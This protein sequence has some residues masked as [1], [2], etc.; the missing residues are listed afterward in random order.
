M[1]VFMQLEAHKRRNLLILFAGGLLFW[2]SLASLL[3]T[4]PQYIE[5]VGASRQQIGIVMGCFAIGLLLSRTKLGHLADQHSR[6]LALIVGT[7]VV[8]LAPLGYLQVD[9]IGWL[10]LLR[11]FHGIS[12]AAFT[13]GYSALVA[14]LSPRYQRGELIG[15]M[16]LVTPTG[17]AL[18]PALGSFLQTEVGYSAL[19]L[20]AGGLGFLSLICCSFVYEPKRMQTDKES[21]QPNSHNIWQLLLSPRLRIPALVLLLAGFAFGAIG[22]FVALF[23]RETGIALNP[24]LYFTTAAIVNFCLRL[25]TGRASDRYGRGLFIS[26]SLICYG[27]AMFLLSTAQTPQGFLLAAM[28]QGAGA[29]TLLPVMIALIADR[30]AANERGRVFSAC[31]SGFDLGIALAGPIFGALADLLGY[32]GIF[33]ITTAFILVALIIFVTQSSQD[34]SHS[35]RFAIGREQ[36]I[37]ALEK[38]MQ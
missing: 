11:A 14:D 29:G 35:L 32:Q 34:L 27:L 31:I 19:F 13:T 33:S 9:S 38:R 37:Y 24:G 12:L 6:K 2:S 20:V 23:I 16:S 22:T 5:D 17:L 8:A 7:S 21:S 36:D 15:Y 1:K 3:P 25:F 4:L 30:S 26:G 28:A 18:G 10:M